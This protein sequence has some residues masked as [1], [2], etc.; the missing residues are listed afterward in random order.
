MMPTTPKGLH[1]S[2]HFT[3]SVGSLTDEARG[4][5]PAGN[6]KGSL[7]VW[8]L[9]L[10]SLLVGVATVAAVTVTAWAN[11]AVIS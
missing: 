7:A 5:S 2:A 11:G 3:V 8:G 6:G 4:F 10:G 9:V 1:M